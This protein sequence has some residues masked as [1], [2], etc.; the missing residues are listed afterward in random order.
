MKL[1]K[2]E[3]PSENAPPHVVGMDAHQR[4]ITLVGLDPEGKVF[5]RETIHNTLPDLDE[6]HRELTEK[7]GNAPVVLGLEA[8]TAGKA[9]CQYLRRLGRDVRMANPRK[10]RALLGETKTDKNDAAALATVLRLGTFPEAYVPTPEIDSLRTIVRL[11][12]EVVEKLKRAKI[13]VRTLLVKNHLQH[14]ASR[15]D[16]IF[17]VQALRWLRDEVK[18]VDR[19]DQRQLVMLLEEG[20][21][22]TRQEHDL[23]T[24]LAKIAVDREEVRILQ[25]LPGIDYTLALTILAEVGDIRRFPNRKKFAAYCGLVPR[26][27]QTGETNPQHTKRRHGN[28]QLTWA[29]EMAVQAI[30][31]SKRGR[32]FL[33]LQRLE[34]RVG[35]AKALTAVAHHL[36]FVAYAI[37]KKGILFEET[38]VP[39]YTVKRRKLAERAKE[40]VRSP[41]MAAIVEKLIARQRLPG[42]LA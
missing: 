17:G 11:R 3:S 31:T 24:Q 6:F 25:S 23:T 20:E 22:Y 27:R 38:F 42:V 4:T 7:I 33:M 18:L 39:R 41:V 9:V 36:S 26:N 12:G 40:E 1:P 35:L 14:D 30:R 21:L 32:F 28:S 34:K 5:L 8:S 19:W 2:P 15:Y 37:W 13:Q 29:F 16:D 10:L